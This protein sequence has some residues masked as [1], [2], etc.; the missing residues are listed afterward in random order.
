MSESEAAPV[1]VFYRYG[2]RGRDMIAIRAPGHMASDADFVGRDIAID[3]RIYRVRAVSRQIS[4]PIH[5]G[6][7]VGVEVEERL[8]RE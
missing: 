8:P 3:N 6:E 2:F 7:P 4:G 5:P 1:E